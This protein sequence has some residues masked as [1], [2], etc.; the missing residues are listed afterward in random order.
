VIKHGINGLLFKAG[1]SDD[2]SKKIKEMK[3]RC[4][5]YE[6]LRYTA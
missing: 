3:D 1:D 4:N 2:L 5:G 6:C